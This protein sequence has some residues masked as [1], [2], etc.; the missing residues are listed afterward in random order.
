[1]KKIALILICIT[2]AAVISG[3]LETPEAQP[4]IVD[5]AVLNSLG[6]EQLDEIQQESIIEYVGDMEIVIN[7]A[8]V[9]YIDKS[10]QDDITR[11]IHDYSNEYNS[12]SDSQEQNQ[13]TSQFM[14]I[15][16]ALPAGISIP[17]SVLIGIVDS[18]IQNM[19]DENGI[20]DF[21]EVGEE[22]VTIST[23]STVKAKSYEG[24]FESEEEDG[25]TLTIRGVLASWTGEGTTTVVIGIIPAQDLEWDVP[26][27]GGTEHLTIEIDKDAEYQD[28]LTLIRNVE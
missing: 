15:R 5:Q 3:C 11:Q 23:G 14:T 24:F 6:W 17:E 26:V 21:Q 4:A 8:V 2:V 27:N 16:M 22:D 28:I 25:I 12:P 20:N 10:L 18:F 19:A 1:M 9:N 7:T 13:F